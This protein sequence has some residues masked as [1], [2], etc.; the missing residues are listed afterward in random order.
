MQLTVTDWAILATFFLVSLLIG[1]LS[2]RKAG[3][4]PD[5][6]FLSGRQMPWWLLGISMVATTFACDTPN[7]VT[8]IVR[9]YGVAGN[10]MW[11]GFL[12]TGM[13]TVFV[14]ARLWRR[15]GVSTDL[16][17]YEMRYG[18]KTAALLRG[19]R[20]LYLGVFFNVVIMAN[21]CLAMTK[22]GAALLGWEAWQTLPVILVITAVYSALGGLRGILLADLFQFLFA[23][24]GSVA[25]AVYLLGLPEVGGLS[26]LLSQPE[27]ASRTDLVPSAQDW[28]VL[29]GLPLLVQWWSVWYPGSEPGGGGYIAQRMLAARDEAGAVKATLLFNLAHYALRPWPWIVVALA[30]LVVF[31]DLESLRQTFP[32]VAPD[33]IQHDFAYPAMLTLLPSGLKGLLLGALVAAFMS[34]ISTQLNW[35]ASYVVYD[36]YSRFVHPE[37]TPSHLVA[38]GR[39][40]TAILLVLTALLA[41]LLQNALQAFQIMLQIGAGTGLIFIL[42]W[43]WWRIN[44]WSEVAGMVISFA[45]ALYLEVLHPLMG[46]EVLSATFKLL[47]GVALTTFGWLSVTLLT[48]PEKQETLLAFYQAV[49]PGGP[50]WRTIEQQLPEGQRAGWNV[51]AGLLNMLLGTVAIYAILFGLGMWIYGSAIGVLGLG[52]VAI[53]AALL[54]GMRVK[55]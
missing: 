11:W 25:A 48:K 28:L 35:G 21:V 37:A 26:A 44:A 7:L 32:N 36:F 2:A 24:A 51:P 12:L 50:G 42:R 40:A 38:A 18:G 54:L 41:L 19:F 20:S 39:I 10:W 30:S 29:M 34:T 33:L 3:S 1:A 55:R 9:Q 14:Y 4:S 53:T 16:A 47:C 46:G 22:I 49:K 5:E 17:F 52:S 8:D 43:F 23:M 15:S 45:V 31:P 27:V 13:L 6:F